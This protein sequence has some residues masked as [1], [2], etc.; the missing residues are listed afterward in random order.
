LKDEVSLKHFEHCSSVVVVQSS[1]KS[2][3]DFSL[4]LLLPAPTATCA[5][6]MVS[7][8]RFYRILPMNF[9]Q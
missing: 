6:G 1:S 3:A 2:C 5:R 8:A 9:F 7:T 4:D